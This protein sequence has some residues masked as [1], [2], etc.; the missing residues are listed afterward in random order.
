MAMIGL[1]A[2]CP[3]DQIVVQRPDGTVG[4]DAVSAGTPL[5]RELTHAELEKEYVRLNPA[6]TRDEELAQAK[7][8]GDAGVGCNAKTDIFHTCTFPMGITDKAGHMDIGECECKFTLSK[9]ALMPGAPG[10][11]LFEKLIGSKC[12]DMGCVPVMAVSVLAGYIGLWWAYSKMTG[13]G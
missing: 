6:M 1:G 9:V 2:S 11:W 8:F 3:G 5:N 10:M 12:S 4:C 7:K 13:K